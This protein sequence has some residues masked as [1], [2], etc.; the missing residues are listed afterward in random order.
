[1]GTHVE[2]ADSI[3]KHLEQDDAIRPYLPYLRDPA[4]PRDAN[5]TEFL[6]NYS[7]SSEGLVLKDGLV[8]VPAADEIKVKILQECH[9]SKTAGHLGQKNTLERV[10][11]DYYWPRMRQFVNEFVDTYETC[12]RNK[13][14][15]HRPQ[16]LLQPL[17]IPTG[18][19]HSVSMDLIVELPKSNGFDAI[20]VCV[21]RL[22]KMAHF[23]PTTSGIS[24]EQTASLYIQQV[25]RL[26]GL[27]VDIVSDRGV[28]FTSRFTRRLLE[29][30]I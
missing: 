20:F 9:D 6:Q 5:I 23:I 3:R 16:G 25:F 24:A 1:V 7:L 21:D 12:A 17:P 10:S 22:T 8:Y 2:L 26:H 29:L 27:P 19:W 4:E 13:V 15:R 30:V 28:Q 18:A 11:R 14:P